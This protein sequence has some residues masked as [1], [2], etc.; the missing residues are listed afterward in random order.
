MDKE[1]EKELEKRRLSEEVRL[2]VERD[3]KR[4]YSWLGIVVAVIMSSV[5]TLTVREILYPARVQLEVMKEMG[6][7]AGEQLVKTSTQY[8]KLNSHFIDLEQ[9]SEM[10]RQK[11]VEA[12]QTNL[13]F[14]DGL[15]GKIADLSSVVSSLNAQ[16]NKLIA[17]AN[18][19][20]IKTDAE[21]KPTIGTIKMGLEKSGENIKNAQEQIGR[22]IR[23]LRPT[24]RPWPNNI[25]VTVGKGTNRVGHKGQGWKQVGPDLNLGAGGDF[26]Y[27]W[28]RDA[29]ADNIDVTVG[30]G[31]NSKGYKGQGWTQV[32]PDLN[33][34]AGGNFLYLWVRDS[35]A[36]NIDVT[37]GKGTNRKGFKGQGWTQL[38]PDLNKGAG[39]NFLY[40][41][42]R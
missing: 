15:R 16:V 13:G 32:G 34:D 25:D 11:L 7:Q 4:R 18:K 27:L 10:L 35:V 37:I 20:E 22:P 17:D 39:G 24:D 36:D 12:S 31:T 28:V 29:V 5:I 2:A 3:L 42:V 9:A 41:W 8:E 6:K 33:R 30:K 21:L 14:T 19:P 1:E 38:G 23:R 40:L 26:L